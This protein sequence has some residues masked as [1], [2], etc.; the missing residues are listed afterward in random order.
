MSSLQ[1][2]KWKRK[3]SFISSPTLMHPDNA[4]SA[5][6]R[7]QVWHGCAEGNLAVY[8]TRSKAAQAQLTVS[9]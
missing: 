7:P 5:Q 9:G 1:I 3:G 4:A 2:L 6:V 8:S